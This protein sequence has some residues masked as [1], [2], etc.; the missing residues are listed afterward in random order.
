MFQKTY[1][2]LKD[3]SQGGLPWAVMAADA[4]SGGDNGDNI[5]VPTTVL[6]HLSIIYSC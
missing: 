4:V 5:H 3:G 6:V 1:Y 2:R